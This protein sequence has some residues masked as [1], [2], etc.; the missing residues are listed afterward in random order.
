VIPALLRVQFEVHVARIKVFV[1]YSR[2]DESLVKPLAGLLGLA[3][4]DAV[5]LDIASIKPGD[6]WKD[7]ID[8]ALREASVFILCWCCESERSQF[9]S[10]EIAIALEGKG[11]RFVPVLFC[12]TPLPVTLEAYQWID[13]RG[14]ITHP[15]QHAATN[16]SHTA[17]APPSTPMRS[18]ARNTRRLVAVCGAAG[19]ILAAAGVGIWSTT[20]SAPRPPTPLAEATEEV[21]RNLQAEPAQASNGIGRMLSDNDQGVF[22]VDRDFQLLGVSGLKCRVTQGDVLQI[23]APPAPNSLSA[24]LVVLAGKGGSEC[25]KGTTVSMQVAD[26]QEMQNHMREAIDTGLGEMRGQPSR[27]RGVGIALVVAL[28]AVLLMA[29]IYMAVR[30]TMR[31]RRNDKIVS[32][33]GAY[34]RRLGNTQSGESV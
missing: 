6:R 3:A 2:H 34:F 19:V 28:A 13:L 9:I 30:K 25:P 27:S 21:T 26:L 23:T 18:S 4:D 7:N 17:A 11:K 29:L 8:G 33:A 10:H 5:F 12:D 16:S 22:V 14:Q 20:R 31:S 32:A 1:S 24:N 15:C